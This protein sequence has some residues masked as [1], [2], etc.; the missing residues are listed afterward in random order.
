MGRLSLIT[1][2]CI[3]IKQKRSIS[4]SPAWNDEVWRQSYGIR[5]SSEQYFISTLTLPSEETRTWYQGMGFI[6][7]DPHMVPTLWLNEAFLRLALIALSKISMSS[8][9]TFRFPCWL[10]TTTSAK[11]PKNGK[12]LPGFARTRRADRCASLVYNL[13]RDTRVRYWLVLT[14]TPDII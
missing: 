14:G 11:P 12:G 7:S 2:I 8:K 9:K 13:A 5:D 1:Q 10:P 3:G 6:N 4:H